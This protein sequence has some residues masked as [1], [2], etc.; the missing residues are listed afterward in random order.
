MMRSVYDEVLLLR[1][2]IKELADIIVKNEI[3][4]IFLKN[5]LNRSV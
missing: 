5:K 4:L 1:R 2:I 3:I